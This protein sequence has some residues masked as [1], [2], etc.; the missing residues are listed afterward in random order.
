MYQTE[1]IYGEMGGRE[2]STI[3]FTIKKVNDLD[4]MNTIDHIGLDKCLVSNFTSRA[5]D[6]GVIA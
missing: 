6:D 4:A 3:Y 2:S 5:C 1:G